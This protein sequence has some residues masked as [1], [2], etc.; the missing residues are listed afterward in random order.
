MSEARFCEDRDC[1]V[2]NRED[3]ILS[4]IQHAPRNEAAGHVPEQGKI[5]V[6][7]IQWRC[8]QT[9]RKDCVCFNYSSNTGKP[10]TKCPFCQSMK[11]RWPSHLPLPACLCLQCT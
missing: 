1:I 9:A 6:E 11:N 2:S 5:R 10:G 8:R 4:G 3:L 7:V